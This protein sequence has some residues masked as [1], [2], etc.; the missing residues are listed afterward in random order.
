MLS[1][2]KVK[3]PVGEIT[4][5]V[6]FFAAA[7][8]SVFA[9]VAILGYILYAS[10]PAFREIGLFRFLFGT[11]WAPTFDGLPASEKFGV[12][13]M[14]VGSL[15]TTLGALLIGGTGG[16][17]IAVF[18]AYY[19]PKKI[20]AF[21]D[22][23]VNL[24]AGIPS[25]VYG[26]FGLTQIV[27]L[28]AAISPNGNGKGLLA[29][30]LVLGLMIL[31]T[32][33]GLTKTSL[34]A[35]PSSYYEG[36]LALGAN[37]N[38]TV[39]RI[40]LPAAKSGTATALGLGIGR[41]V[42]ETMA[43]LM[44][45]GNSA[46]FPE[47]L[48]DNFRTLTTNIALEMSYAM[49]LHRNAL[50][51]TGSILLVFVLLLNLA[52]HVFRYRSGKGK[53]KE[54]KR[55]PLSGETGNT[56]VYRYCPT[57]TRLLKGTAIGFAAFLGLALAYLV[58]Y[59]LIQG[60]PHISLDLLFGE[61]TNGHRTLAPAFVSTGII[62]GISL[63]ISLPIGIGA[64]VYLSEY[65]KKGSFAVKVIRLFTDTLSGIPS[66]V[67]GLFGM[68][69]FNS[70]FGYSL[71]SGALSVSLMILP[72]IVRST[73]ESLIA[74]P[75]SL[76]E[77]SYALGASKVRTIFRVILPCAFRGILS[78]VI[79]AIG[80]IVGES[81]IFIFTAGS[82]ALMPDGLL[83]PGSTFAVMMYM[84]ASEAEYLDEA[85][86]TAAI[87]LILVSALYALVGWIGNRQRRK[88]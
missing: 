24:L 81:A 27:P 31:P 3:K 60:L 87:L 23:M 1:D 14:I 53:N 64:A 37:K 76:R 40:L 12:L 59:V 20:R 74:V 42:G 13:P 19:C 80:R 67:F 63:L 22:Q 54:K 71:L 77:A 48:F 32:V 29:V 25:I 82:T 86:A 57:A 50:I 34:E 62:I 68:I 26:F 84:F 70:I 11:L 21:F 4:A 28:L 73:E 79:L 66:I 38:Q 5:R 39:F 85:Y 44:I 43:I 78:A 61:S 15:C 55:S 6:L 56:I 8:F 65:A 45:A 33:A 88:V 7:V 46:V 52:L 72:T 47:G 9:V 58:C 51:A 30:S 16:V 36:A 41:A 49:G 2:G 10:I 83:S 69:A 18:A 75:E 35:V 17:F